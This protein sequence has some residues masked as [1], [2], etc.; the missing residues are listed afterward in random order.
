M[1]EVFLLAMFLGLGAIAVWLHVRYPGRRPGSLLR[2]AAHVVFSFIGFGLVP[3]ALS[4]VLTHLSPSLL[5][6]YVG[7]GI[8]M[9]A[10]TYWLLSWIWLLA[11]I[12]S[13][14]DG[15]PRGGLP[16]SNES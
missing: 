11:R 5:R 16:A 3:G 7:L 15:T 10:V 2:A 12:I 4:L 9:P 1:N 13:M 6:V 14:L 8:V